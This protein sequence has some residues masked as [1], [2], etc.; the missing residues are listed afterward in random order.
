MIS[1]TIASLSDTMANRNSEVMLALAQ[2]RGNNTS[3]KFSTIKEYT[4]A[5]SSY[6]LGA[7]LDFLYEANGEATGSVS[8]GKDYARCF[9]VVRVRAKGYSHWVT[10][11]PDTATEEE[12]HD[13]VARI[14]DGQWGALKC[15]RD[16]RG[17]VE[18]PK[19]LSSSEDAGEFC[20]AYEHLVEKSLWAMTI[21]KRLTGK[22]P[23]NWKH[24]E[25]ELC[26]Y[27]MAALPSEWALALEE[28]YLQQE[29][30]LTLKTVGLF[31]LL[32]GRAGRKEKEDQLDNAHM[33]VVGGLDRPSPK[34]FACNEAGHFQRN[35]P[36]RSQSR[37]ISPPAEIRCF[38]CQGNHH[39]NQCPR[40]NRSQPSPAETSS[41]QGVTPTGVSCFQCGGPH[42]KRECPQ[43]QV[44][45][46][47]MAPA[48]R[49][50]IQ[51][52]HCQGPHR[53][54]DCPV[55]AG[56]NR[57]APV[58]SG[59]QS[60]TSSGSRVCISCGLP[61]GHMYRDCPTY[62][63]RRNTRAQGCWACGMQG[64]NQH[65]SGCPKAFRTPRGA[66]PVATGSNAIPIGDRRSPTPPT[67]PTAMA[68]AAGVIHPDRLGNTTPSPS[69]AGT[70]Q[71]R[72][73]P[74]CPGEVHRLS[75]CSKFTGCK[76]CGSRRHLKC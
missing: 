29:S 60:Q 58:T 42:F 21:L 72:E 48:Q 71:Q 11:L 55:L 38:H 63:Q 40:V 4:R 7:L 5:K 70:S 2:N 47:G 12:W 30:E 33:G 59:F 50:S 52:Y 6:N 27:L 54:R 46:K 26:H 28:K 74:R 51:C 13:L 67:R 17:L 9:K 76:D 62:Q 10:Q 19:P 61:T 8:T 39:V 66:G 31:A 36:R 32:R 68:S 18:R 35:C 75:E 14:L 56:V 22:E 23:P 37:Q 20:S 16:I 24:D 43:N 1:T 53:K 65:Q 44:S 49:G 15:T 3:E 41:R 25:S 57:E 69:V 73:C 45:G 64:N 34:C